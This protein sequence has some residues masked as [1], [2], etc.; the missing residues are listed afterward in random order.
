MFGALML[1]TAISPGS[2]AQDKLESNI[3]NSS[4]LANLILLTSTI[5]LLMMVN[6]FK[7]IYESRQG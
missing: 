5:I 3:A 2:M 4:K 7:V 1:G 6:N